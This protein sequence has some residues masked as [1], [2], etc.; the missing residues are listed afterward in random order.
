MQFGMNDDI[1]DIHNEEDSS[2]EN[3]FN[4]ILN[5]GHRNGDKCTL[6]DN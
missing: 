2:L 4:K 6:F 5:L 1:P 3:T